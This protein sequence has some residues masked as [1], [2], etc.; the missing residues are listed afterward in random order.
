M[1]IE[2]LVEQKKRREG[3]GKGA[4]RR[5][6]KIT[7]EAELAQLD[8]SWVTYKA[9]WAKSENGILDPAKVDEIRRL[10]GWSTGATYAALE[11]ALDGEYEGSA[12]GGRDL[13]SAPGWKHVRAERKGTSA[14][15]A[16]MEL[17]G[18]STEAGS[19]RIADL[20]DRYARE[21]EVD[22]FDALMAV[23][24]GER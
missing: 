17:A 16:A 22:Y 21:H 1:L 24:R 8:H 13:L 20:A 19:K 7:T 6:R 9:E 18:T 3:N 15:E 10:R 23:Q 5:P 2:S 4:D 11:A 12:E 14:A